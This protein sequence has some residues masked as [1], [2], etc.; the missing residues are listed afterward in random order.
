MVTPPSATHTHSQI[1][2]LSSLVSGSLS[3]TEALGWSKRMKTTVR[4]THA[5]TH[6]RTLTVGESDW[7]GV[8]RLPSRGFLSRCGGYNGRAKGTLWE[9]LEQLELVDLFRIALKSNQKQ[10]ESTK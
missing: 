8:Q 3:V 9:Q 2:A 6:T 7:R 4:H 10:K 5:L 1:S